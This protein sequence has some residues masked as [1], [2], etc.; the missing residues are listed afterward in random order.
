MKIQ[1]YISNQIDVYF[2]TCKR[3]RK[4]KKTKQKKQKKV[5]QKGRRSPGTANHAAKE[6]VGPLRIHVIY[7][8]ETD[9]FNVL[10]YSTVWFE[11]SRIDKGAIEGKL[12]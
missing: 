1:E 5:Q 3:E 4:Q 2:W 6:N 7:F 12:L 9:S 11:L 10:N 8:Y